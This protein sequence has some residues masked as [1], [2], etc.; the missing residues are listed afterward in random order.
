VNSQVISHATSLTLLAELMGTGAPSP[1]WVWTAACLWLRVLPLVLLVPWLSWSSGARAMPSVLVAVVA[2][3]LWCVW[4]PAVIPVSTL[5]TP[6]MALWIAAQELWLGSVFA[7]V[8]ALPIYALMWAAQWMLLAWTRESRAAFVPALWSEVYGLAACAL[9]LALGGHRAVLNAVLDMLAA[10]PVGVSVATIGLA[11]ALSGFLG[12][13]R[14]SVEVAVV[15]ALPVLV[16]LAILEWLMGVVARTTWPA[17]MALVAVPLRVVV[18][19]TVTLFATSLLFL[20]LDEAW[21]AR[22]V[23]SLRTLW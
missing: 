12:A 2:S 8:T 10:W 14:H 19:C 6:P 7:A 23:A 18:G 5:P 11:K 13:A 9:F 16:S 4:L 15:V 1:A 20:L 3:V 21:I 17:V 22:S